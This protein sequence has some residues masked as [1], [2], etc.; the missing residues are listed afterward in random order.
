MQNVRPRLVFLVTEDWYF[1][2]HRLPMAFAAQRAGYDVHVACRVGQ[3]GADDFLVRSLLGNRFSVV[4]HKAGVAAG[5]V[6][7]ANFEELRLDSRAGADRITLDHLAGSGL[8]TVVL[9]A[10]KAVGFTKESYPFN[11]DT[12][13]VG[14]LEPLLLPWSDTKTLRYKWTGSG[15][16]KQ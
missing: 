14:G 12:S 8:G 16:E 5:G 9:S 13:A 15:F 10:G 3:K 4:N 1:L 2:M 6:N 7:A 11:Q